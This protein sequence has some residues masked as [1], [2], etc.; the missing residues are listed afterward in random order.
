MRAWGGLIN[1]NI[2]RY[3]LRVYIYTWMML[4]IN[5]KNVNIP[6]RFKSYTEKYTEKKNLPRRFGEWIWY[7]CQI[8]RGLRHDIMSRNKPRRWV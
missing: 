2:E 5:K 6:V 7:I 3:V 8:L 4:N 1:K